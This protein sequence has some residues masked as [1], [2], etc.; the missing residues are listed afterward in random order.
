MNRKE[1]AELF[2]GLSETLTVLADQASHSDLPEDIVVF[3]KDAV[4]AIV[5]VLARAI[6][7]ISESAR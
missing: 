2:N 5:A 6:V 7:A 1:F 4:P 3:E